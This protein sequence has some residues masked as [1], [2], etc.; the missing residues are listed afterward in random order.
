MYYIKDNDG[1]VEVKI[2][3]EISISEMQV[4]K[5]EGIN[6]INSL[7]KRTNCL[8]DVTK[9]D[10]VEGK[11]EE[12]E[13]ERLKELLIN[14]KVN[15]GALVVNGLISKMKAQVYLRKIKEKEI[16]VFTDYKEAIEFCKN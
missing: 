13:I 6:K 9:L 12:D 14:S 1:Y 5:K 3:G 7:T 16:K 2:E 11:M 10:G 4:M 8:V 15:K